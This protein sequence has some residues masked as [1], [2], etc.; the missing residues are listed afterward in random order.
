MTT[1]WF[2]RLSRNKRVGSDMYIF[3]W[4]VCVVASPFRAMCMHLLGEKNKSSL[5][6]PLQKGHILLF[7]SLHMHM[8]NIPRMLRG[9]ACEKESVV[10]QLPENYFFVSRRRPESFIMFQNVPKIVGIH[11]YSR[12]YQLPR[13]DA[14]R[15]ACNR[16][17]YY[18]FFNIVAPPQRF[19]QQFFFQHNAC[20]KLRACY[21]LP[22]VLGHRTHLPIA[23]LSCLWRCWAALFDVIFLYIKYTDLI[24]LFFDICVKEKN[25]F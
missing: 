25:I 24:L 8:T 14:T 20:S 21:Y 6:Q 12:V 7:A 3:T 11:N 23:C 18:I 5:Q 2:E 17:N 19:P 1:Y 16:A 4:Y 22:S 15:G 13:G 10:L 9:A